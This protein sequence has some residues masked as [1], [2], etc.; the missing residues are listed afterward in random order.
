[1]KNLHTKE[2][3]TKKGF[4]KEYLSRV[5]KIW[6]SEL[7]AFNKTIAHNAFAAPVI[8]LTIGILDWATQEIKDIDIRTRKNLSVAGNFHPNSDVDRLYIGQNIGGGDL[9]SCQSLKV[10]L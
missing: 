10:E 7:S 5:K 4:S 8:R 3:L 2:Q 1:M 9:R 6:S